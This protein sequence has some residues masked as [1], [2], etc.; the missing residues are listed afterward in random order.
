M[1][2]ERDI[3]DLLF[4]HDCVIVP[5][6]GGFLTHYRHARLDTQ[7]RMLH[8]PSK[9]LSFNGHLVRQDGLL[10][11]HYSR[12]EG[13]TFK[14]A[15]E[16]IGE[17]TALWN[18]AL[19]RQ[20]RV[21]LPRIGTFFLD[22]ELNLQFEPD[23]RVN[24]LKDAYGLRPVAAHP[25]A[26]TASVVVAKPK[27]VPLVSIGS[28]PGRTAPGML[29]AAAMAAILFTAATWWAV[30]S[31]GNNNALWSSFDFLPGAGRQ[32]YVLPLSPPA[33]PAVPLAEE[34]WV[35]PKG[36]EGV[37]L[38]PIAGDRA[39]VVAVD[40]STP[41][42]TSAAPESTAVA[43]PVVRAKYHVVGGCFLEKEN[44]DRFIAELQAKGFAASLIDHKGGLYRVAYGSYPLRTTALEALDAVRSEEAPDAWMLV[45]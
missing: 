10:A 42:G 31:T 15:I 33:G 5:G 6:F 22:A 34:P 28:K 40:L 3:H 43:A 26:R 4:D 23:R 12:R 9:D 17:Q 21:E 11:D 45:K 27:V 39:P 37:H 38:Y 19:T 32:E 44:A 20:G 29:T 25:V 2:L 35:A 8:P 18:D 24:F 1:A 30:T 41:Q 36:S 7:R 14:F 16:A 13:V